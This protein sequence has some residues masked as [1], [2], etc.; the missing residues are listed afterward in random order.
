MNPLYTLIAAALIIFLGA[1]S[2]PKSITPKNQHK[3][4]SY[5]KRPRYR[6]PI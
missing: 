5:V 3:T 4:A 1:V 6:R 2:Q